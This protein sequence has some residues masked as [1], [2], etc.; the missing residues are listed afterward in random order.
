M[1]GCMRRVSARNT[2]RSSGIVTSSPSTCWSTLSPL[3]WGCTALETCGS[4]EGSPS[5]T[6]LRAD[7]AAASASASA[8][9]PASS[10]SSTSTGAAAMSLPANSHVVPA[11]TLNSFRAH[12]PLVV[13][14]LIPSGSSSCR[15]GLS[16]HRVQTIQLAGI[17][18]DVDDLVEEVVDGEVAEGGDSDPQAG[19]DQ[20]AHELGGPERLARPRWTLDGDVAVV[21]LR[22]PGCHL[23][24]VV[25]EP[26]ARRAAARQERRSVPAQQCHR[27][28][29]GGRATGIEDPGGQLV[30]RVG[31]RLLRHPVVA[32]H[33]AR[34][35]ADL[36]ASL[37]PDQLDHGMF[38]IE[39][40]DR[41]AA[42][43]AVDGR[44]HDHVTTV[45]EAVGRLFGEGELHGRTVEHV[46]GLPDARHLADP[47]EASQH[48]RIVEQLGR[49]ALA[50]GQQRSDVGQ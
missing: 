15:V 50:P 35:E 2:P 22:R 47:G 38:P 27:H 33:D 34:H 25:A 7:R 37:V 44:E 17:G 20:R 12:G 14:Y 45:D 6:R 30:D 21:E 42:D 46:A 39:A 41:A 29:V 28:G 4:W 10:T 31:L 3:R 23:G 5:S 18:E 32:H 26:R 9:W 8:S 40:V 36:L 13:T 16:T 49:I 11:T 1:S 19:T 24:E 48:I 43:S